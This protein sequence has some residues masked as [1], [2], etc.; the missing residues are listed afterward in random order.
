VLN[1]SSK[2]SNAF[3]K[4]LKLSSE[5]SECKPLIGGEKMPLAMLRALAIVKQGPHSPRHAPHSVPVLATSST[6]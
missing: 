1:L 4:V 5:V 3:P 2:V 6:T